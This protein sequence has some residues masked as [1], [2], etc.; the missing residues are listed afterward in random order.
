MLLT[1]FSLLFAC[2]YPSDGFAQY[3]NAGRK[4]QPRISN[5]DSNAR[6]EYQKIFE[7]IFTRCG[8]SY[9]AER[10]YVYR[11]IGKKNPGINDAVFNTNTVEI[12]RLTGVSF[13]VFSVPLNE[14]DRRNGFQWRGTARIS[15]GA[16]SAQQMYDKNKGWSEWK[17]AFLSYYELRGVKKKDLPWQFPKTFDYENDG[18]YSFKS[19]KFRKLTCL[20]IPK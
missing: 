1:F 14:A 20:S 8:D 9:Y 11:T 13:A 17:S 10:T 3:R 15:S 12:V 6:D 18:E 2:S 19:E 16:N 5:L 7:S 4:S